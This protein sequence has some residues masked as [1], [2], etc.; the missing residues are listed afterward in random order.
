M[1]NHIINGTAKAIILT[2]LWNYKQL[3]MCWVW[4]HHM[5]SAVGL[6]V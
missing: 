5:D 4:Q 1:I 6:S 2:L 3:E